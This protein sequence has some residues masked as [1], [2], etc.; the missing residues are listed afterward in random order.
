MKHKDADAMIGDLIC[1]SDFHTAYFALET[2]FHSVRNNQM[3]S[4]FGLSTGNDRFQS[5]LARAREAHGELVDYIQPV[6][7]EQQRQNDIIQ[8]RGSITSEEHRFF[9]ALLLN[10][11]SREKVLELVKSR[12]P[13]SDPV[14]KIL[15]WVEELSQTRVLGSKEPN[16]LGIEGFDDDH[17]FILEHLLKGQS[18]Q[19]IRRVIEF[20]DL[21]SFAGIG[22][23][24]DAVAQGLQN[25]P[26]FKTILRPRA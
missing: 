2:F 13:E 15:D 22:E 7:E 20:E 8:R 25:S 12:F 19:E 18:V 14:E 16:A 10:V 5:I 4:L 24:L 21:R 1:S 17:M 11:P 3:D 23:K 9:L 26:L 6:F